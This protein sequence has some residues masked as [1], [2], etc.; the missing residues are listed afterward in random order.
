M[1]TF[2]RVI[3]QTFIT[4]LMK[5]YCSYIFFINFLVELENLQYRNG[6]LLS[7]QVLKNTNDPKLKLLIRSTYL[8]KIN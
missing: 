5:V 3:N 8:R 4:Y 2:N 6:D 7:I 1:L